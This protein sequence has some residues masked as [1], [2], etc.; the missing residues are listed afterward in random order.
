MTFEEWWSL[1]W[2][3]L[4]RDDDVSAEAY[5]FMEAHAKG[6]AAKAWEFSRINLAEEMSRS[7]RQAELEARERAK[8]QD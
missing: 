5:R 8:R 3:A 6:Y 1:A 2:P 7:A 4:E